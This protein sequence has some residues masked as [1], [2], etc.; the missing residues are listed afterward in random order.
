MGLPPV[1]VLGGTEV[2]EVLV[3]GEDLDREGGSM[4]VVPP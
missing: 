1:K 3:V 2:G 4:E